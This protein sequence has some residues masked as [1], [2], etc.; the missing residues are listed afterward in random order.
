MKNKQE[1]LD[2]FGLAETDVKEL[3]KDPDFEVLAKSIENPTKV[4]VCDILDGDGEIVISQ[5][6]P[7]RVHHEVPVKGYKEKLKKRSLRF[8][9][10]F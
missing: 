10:W 6:K 7:A 2:H 3:G 8:I 5:G 4:A 9:G 1:I